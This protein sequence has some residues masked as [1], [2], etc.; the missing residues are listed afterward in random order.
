[1]SLKGVIFDLDGTLGDTLPVCFAAFREVFRT[2]LGEEYS[3]QQIRGLL[4]PSEE[5]VLQRAI[6]NHFPATFEAYLA[7]YERAHAGCDRAF[8]G[9]EDALDLLTLRGVRRGLVTAKGRRSAEITLRFLGLA[10]RFD[11]IEA[12]SAEGNIKADNMR[13]V[14]AAWGLEPSAVACLGDAPSDIRAAREVGAM[15]LAAAWAS[16]VQ[17]ATLESAGPSVIFATVDEFVAWLRQHLG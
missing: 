4:G 17:L 5:G 9:I 13:R 12:G 7:A 10:G 11:P 2:Y 6:P 1:M 3:D 14:L 8:C 16:T 15:P